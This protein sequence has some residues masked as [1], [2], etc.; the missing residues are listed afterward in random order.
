M[1]FLT[2]QQLEDIRRFVMVAGRCIQT[3]TTSRTRVELAAEYIKDNF[4]NLNL[5]QFTGL[6]D[7]SE[8]AD[9]FYYFYKFLENYSDN[10]RQKRTQALL[11]ALRHH[12]SSIFRFRYGS[13]TYFKRSPDSKEV[14]ETYH[15]TRDSQYWTLYF[16]IGMPSSTTPGSEGYEHQVLQ[17]HLHTEEDLQTL[18]R[19]RCEHTG[20]QG[21]AY[22]AYLNSLLRKGELPTLPP[23]VFRDIYKTNKKPI[24]G[25]D[26]FDK[27]KWSRKDLDLWN[28][29]LRS[30]FS[31]LAL[32]ELF[33]ASRE[34]GDA[35]QLPEFYK[36]YGGE[37]VCGTMR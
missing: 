24:I 14:T 27:W 18:P 31:S 36:F 25:K 11:F 10:Q 34:K 19:N 5:K 15:P 26:A 9:Q 3:F 37:R 23:P 32:D 33:R 8:I 22:C 2:S 35:R 21:Y 13:I 20:C 30:W 6:P 28:S 1:A 12:L 17:Q 29:C 16:P 7:T 4:R